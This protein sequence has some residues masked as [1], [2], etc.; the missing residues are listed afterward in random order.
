MVLQ[1]ECSFKVNIRGIYSSLVLILSYVY[2]LYTSCFYRI[3]RWD[4]HLD[5]EASVSR[6]V[7]KG[8]GLYSYSTIVRALHPKSVDYLL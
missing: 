4:S 1:H 7:W 2:T 5:E 6:Q 8:A 3:P